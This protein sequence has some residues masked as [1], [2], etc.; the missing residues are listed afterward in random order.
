MSQDSNCNYDTYDSVVVI[1]PDAETARN[2]CVGGVWGE[3][4]SVWCDSPD[5]VTVQYLG[6]AADEL[7]AEYDTS[8]VCTICSSFNA[9]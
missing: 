4:Y 8:Q 7:I 1:A 9:G 5:D 3:R 2:Y 6:E